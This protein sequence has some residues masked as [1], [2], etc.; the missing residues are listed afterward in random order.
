MKIREHTMER[1]Q[2]I[3]EADNGEIA[4]ACRLAALRDFEKVARE[5]FDLA[6]EPKLE[7]K[8][9]NK[10]TLVTLTFSSKR[11]KNFTILK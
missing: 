3:L 8:H 4:E 11:V 10:E 5:Y 9:V 2:A 7:M 1:I 6:G